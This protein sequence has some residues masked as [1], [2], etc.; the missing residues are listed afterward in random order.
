MI[1]L[2]EKLD[3]KFDTI[4]TEEQCINAL[5][6]YVSSDMW[7]NYKDIIL[8]K[9]G[10]ANFYTERMFKGICRSLYNNWFV[11]DNWYGNTGSSEND[12]LKLMQEKLP[13]V[14]FQC[15]QGLAS[16][17]KMIRHNCIYG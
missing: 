4:T 8:E 15:F 12:I 3:S 6:T 13:P 7:R 9:L 14:Y 17:H 1:N 2:I 11:N 16:V 10:N 5:D